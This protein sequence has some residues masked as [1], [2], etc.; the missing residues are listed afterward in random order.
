MTTESR[1]VPLG[2]LDLVPISARPGRRGHLHHPTGLGRR[3]ERAPDGP[4]GG[5]GVR[6]RRS[7]EQAAR[8]EWS[9][10]DRALVADRTDTQFVG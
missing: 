9:E 2:V 7:P 6:A 8:H 3:A 10:E 1:R 4:V 5:R